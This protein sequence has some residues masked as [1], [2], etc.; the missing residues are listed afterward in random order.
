MSE[1]IKSKFLVVSLLLHIASSVL[2][3]KGQNGVMKEG[4]VSV[5]SQLGGWVGGATTAGTS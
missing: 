2:S 4:M 1:K 3:D 5:I